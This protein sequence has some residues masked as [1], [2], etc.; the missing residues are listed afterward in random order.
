MLKSE[1]QLLNKAL[2][3]ATF[4]HSQ[5]CRDIINFILVNHSLRTAAAISR[6][7]NNEY[8]LSKDD[9]EIMKEISPVMTFFVDDEDLDTRAYIITKTRR[10]EIDSCE[11]FGKTLGYYTASD[12]F[13]DYSRERMKYY[14]DAT[15]D[16]NPWKLI[17][18]YSEVA[19]IEE[20]HPEDVKEY[21]HE[22]VD[23]WNE[24]FEK[25]GI[26]FDSKTEFVPIESDD[27]EERCDNCEK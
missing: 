25:T 24:L 8:Y 15:I 7:N 9:I 26:E 2:E 18:V 27:E 20:F 14:V 22:M 10:I 11:K 21:F 12:T 17:D 5:R 4:E 16:R 13:D 23:N 3:S 6:V 19:V 1:L